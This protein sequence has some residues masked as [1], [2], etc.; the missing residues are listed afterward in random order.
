MPMRLILA[1][2]KQ[3]RDTKVVAQ[4]CSSFATKHTSC[5]KEN[6]VFH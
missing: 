5:Y 6:K 4:K 3:P 1:K 2:A